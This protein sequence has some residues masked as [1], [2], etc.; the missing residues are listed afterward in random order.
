LGHKLKEFIAKKNTTKQGKFCFSF[1]PIAQFRSK[2]N[3]SKIMNN[4]DT[5]KLDQE[6][7]QEFALIP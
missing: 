5:P 4:S 2:S 7:V 3:F 1:K 6:P